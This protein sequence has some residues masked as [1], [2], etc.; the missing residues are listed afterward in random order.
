MQSE[1]LTIERRQVDLDAGTVRLDPGTTK[2]DDRRLVYL[3]PELKALVT[4][5]LGRVDALQ[6]KRERIIPWLFPNLRGAVKPNAGRRRVAVLGDRRRDFRKVWKSA[7]KAAGVPGMLRHDCRRTAVRNMVNAGVPERVA[8][9][10]TGHQGHNHGH[11]S[12]PAVDTRPAS[13]QNP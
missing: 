5:Q 7:C 3:T 6:K 12:Q 1:V 11:S 9:T 10:V 2:N 4:A 13:T 8:M